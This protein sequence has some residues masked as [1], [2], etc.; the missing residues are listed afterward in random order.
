MAF[1]KFIK[2][3]SIGLDKGCHLINEGT[4]SSGADAVHPLLHIV[5]FKIYDLCVLASKL[6]CHVGFGIELF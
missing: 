1:G 2:A 3:R 4:G 5:I 6:Y